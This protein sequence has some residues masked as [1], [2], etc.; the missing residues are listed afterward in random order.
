[1]LGCAAP[2]LYGSSLSCL[3]RHSIMCNGC[4]CATTHRLCAR[5]IHVGEVSVA[6]YLHRTSLP[7]TCSG[8]DGKASRGLR[9]DQTA[10][11]LTHVLPGWMGRWC[12]QSLEPCIKVLGCARVLG[13]VQGCWVPSNGVPPH[14]VPWVD[15]A[16][17][18]RVNTVLDC[19]SLL[20]QLLLVAACV[21]CQLFVG[22]RVTD[23]R[24]N[25]AVRQ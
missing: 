22:A 19:D 10:S 17:P 21:S 18:F 20:C 25:T 5:L 2:L 15:G 14:C 9:V 23:T 1:M 11:P 7:A 24:D 3:V 8:L 4:R 16:S 13:C 6:M 12:R